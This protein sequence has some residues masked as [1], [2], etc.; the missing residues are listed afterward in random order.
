M[1]RSKTKSTRFPAQQYFTY[2]ERVIELENKLQLCS[3]VA[4]GTSHE[5]EQDSSR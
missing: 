5:A 1:Q 3:E 4:D 2:I